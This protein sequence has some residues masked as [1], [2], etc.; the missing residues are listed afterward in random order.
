M[1]FERTVTI[2]DGESC[3]CGIKKNCIFAVYSRS[4]NASNCRLYHKML[5]GGNYP[6]KCS[7]CMNDCKEAGGNDEA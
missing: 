4:K 6:L 1:T 2:P 5:K 7:E 3:V